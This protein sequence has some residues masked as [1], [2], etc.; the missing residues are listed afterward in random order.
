MTQAT[1][2]H[3]N[4]RLLIKEQEP[5]DIS[6]LGLPHM[7]PQ[8]CKTFPEAPNSSPRV[9]N[10]CGLDCTRIKKK[11]KNP[12]KDGGNVGGTKM[13]VQAERETLEK[14]G[15]PES[16]SVRHRAES[17]VHDIERQ[18]TGSQV[19][20]RAQEFPILQCESP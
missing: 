1:G 4:Q 12:R 15:G 18:K 10:A 9:Q 3:L 8:P 20:M 11:K 17:G 6:H 2:Q 13:C 19:W 16:G 14:W 5:A 7:Q